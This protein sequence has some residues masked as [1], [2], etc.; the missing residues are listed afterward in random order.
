M[1]ENPVLIVQSVGIILSI[2]C[3]NATGVA[4]TKYASAAQRSTIDTCR[5]LLIWVISLMLGQETF[6]VPLSFG[7]A[8]GFVALVVGTLIYNE[9][10]ILPCE[11]LNKNT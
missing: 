2:S 9:I 6:D 8:A 11:P 5:T 7:Q 3:F 10:W 4:I 1:G